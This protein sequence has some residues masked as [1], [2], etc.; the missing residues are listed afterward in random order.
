MSEWAARRSWPAALDYNLDE[1][2]WA[3]IY[4][5]KNSLAPPAAVGVLAGL[6]ILYG[7][8]RGRT[9][10]RPW[11]VGPLLVLVVAYDLRILLL[12][13]SKVSLAGLVAVGLV[14]I[15]M[16]A[17]SVPLRRGTNGVASFLERWSFPVF[18]ACAGLTLAMNGRISSLF[19]RAAG[20]TGRDLYWGETWTAFVD[21]PVLGWGWLAP[22][23]ADAFR[24]RLPVELMGETWSHNAFLDILAGGGVVAAALMLAALWT[25][26]NV[27]VR[28]LARNSGTGGWS[29]L[30]MVFVL[31]AATQ[32]S[33]VI[34]NHFLYA[35][36]VAAMGVESLRDQ[37]RETQ[38]GNDSRRVTMWSAD[39]PSP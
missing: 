27:Q 25:G 28:T 24:S 9:A 20:F 22:W 13:R 36:L 4:L 21:R 3:G 2:W 34:G 12:T 17:L 31:I 37:G 5:N 30:L 15:L 23:H 11:L 10:G 39:R 38:N 6:V 33:F 26:W 35:L 8:L 18:A 19:G 14:A 29:I 1:A 32:E 7:V 16:L